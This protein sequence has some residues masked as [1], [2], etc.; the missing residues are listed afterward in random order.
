MTMSCKRDTKIRKVRVI[1]TNTYLFNISK[2][3]NYENNNDFEISV[4][5]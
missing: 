2:V 5:C 3:N 1:S 4:L